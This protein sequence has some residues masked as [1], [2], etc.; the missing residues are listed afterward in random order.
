MDSMK[1]PSEV[2]IA[3]EVAPKTMVNLVRY[4]DGGWGIT[5]AG[6][7]IGIWEHAELDECFNVFALQVG[8]SDRHTEQTVVLRIR[9]VA[10]AALN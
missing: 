8:I 5:K 7:T 4:Q 6:T 2:V 3:C 10:D 1:G 9:S